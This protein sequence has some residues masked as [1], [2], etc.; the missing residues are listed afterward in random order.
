[1]KL[2][3]KKNMIMDRTCGTHIYDSGCVVLL[4]KTITQTSN[5]NTSESCI[6]FLIVLYMSHGVFIEV[7]AFV[8]YTKMTFTPSL[9]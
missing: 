4:G 5:L 1:M 2:V 8:I 3:H 7:L 9:D 6:Q